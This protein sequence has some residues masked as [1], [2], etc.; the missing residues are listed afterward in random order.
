MDPMGIVRRGAV[1][2]TCAALAAAVSLGCGSGRSPAMDALEARTT[3]AEISEFAGGEAERCVFSAPDLELCSWRLGPED[4]AWASQAS[5]AGTDGE[6]NLVCELPID[7]SP[8]APGS[9]LPHARAAQAATA[10]GGDLPAVSAPGSLE[11]RRQAAQRLAE[12]ASLRDLAHALGDAPDR[13]RTGA[14]VQ[15]CEWSLDEGAGGYAL[16]ASLVE[17]AGPV[18]AVRLSCVLPLDGSARGARSCTAAAVE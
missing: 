11:A 9:C 10:A 6:V 18:A 5:A 3:R 16:V 8:R 2:A 12:A 1:P 14:G 7:G 17:S 15:T 4:P 13:C